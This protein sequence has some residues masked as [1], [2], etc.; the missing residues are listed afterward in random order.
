[1]QTDRDGYRQTGTQTSLNDCLIE[2]QMDEWMERKLGKIAST[3]RQTFKKLDRQTSRY[4]QKEKHAARQTVKHIRR[5]SIQ[6]R[7]TDIQ[8]HRDRQGE[9]PTLETPDIHRD[10]AE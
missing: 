10:H 1:M 8:V 2:R 4:R 7:Q 5:T 6:G 3:D 9:K